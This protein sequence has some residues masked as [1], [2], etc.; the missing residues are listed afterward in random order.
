V[1]S[2]PKNEVTDWAQLKPPAR[3]RA[4]EHIQPGGDPKPT[5][6][7]KHEPW[8]GH[9]SITLQRKKLHEKKKGS[10]ATETS[11]GPT[12]RNHRIC[13][14]GQLLPD[15][16][17]KRGRLTGK[18]ADGKRPNN[19]S[20]IWGEAHRKA[21]KKE[22]HPTPTHHRGKN[23]P[24]KSFKA[25]RASLPKRLKRYK[26]RNREGKLTGGSQTRNQQLD[27]NGERKR[28]GID[29]LGEKLKK[30]RGTKEGKGLIL[31]Q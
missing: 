1:A 14:K 7:K 15:Y 29:Q 4:R 2:P 20:R 9:L 24:G 25:K 16:G 22:T 21:T 10:T 8:T 19:H 11:C 28:D 5:K 31:V 18:F 13:L 3:T 12:Q 26:T 27:T 23:R 6:Q 30:T 17:K